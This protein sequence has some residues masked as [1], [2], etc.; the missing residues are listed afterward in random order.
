[1]RRFV[2][3]LIAFG[4][5][6]A[7]A[8]IAHA[9]SATIR[10]T[11]ATQTV[12]SDSTAT[13]QLQAES[14]TDPDG[15]AAYE[16]ALNFDPNVLT[17]AT[18]TNADFLGSTGR[19]VVCLPP[20]FDRDGDDQDDPGYVRVGCVSQGSQQPPQAGPT[21]SGLLGTFTFDTECA[22]TTDLEFDRADLADPLGNPFETT[23]IEGS[24]TVTGTPCATPTP[25]VTL[26]DVNCDGEVTAIDAALILQL[27]AGLID[28]LNCEAAG[29]VNGDGDITAVDAAIILQFVAGIID[30][31]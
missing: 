23:S 16:V 27:N 20:R 8:Q 25:E 13:I 1:M 22:A 9:E 17:Y 10:I 31:L 30:E 12:P 6:L 26:G 4:L 19:S 14:I 3:P 7:V 24:V 21:G 15:L 28:E 2:L 29:D 18:F 5:V 11:P